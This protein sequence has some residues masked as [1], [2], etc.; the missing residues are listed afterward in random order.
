MNN[1][2][3]GLDILNITGDWQAT[4]DTF[5]SDKYDKMS[6]KTYASWGEMSFDKTFTMI[7]GEK[8]LVPM[9][10]VIDSNSDKPLT[11]RAGISA[12]NGAIPELG[13]RHDYTKD[14][15]R[16]II[17]QSQINGEMTAALSVLRKLDV[18]TNSLV[19]GIHTR[20]NNLLFQELSAGKITVTP[21]NNPDGITMA[22]SMPIPNDNK[23]YAGFNRG[24]AASWTSDTA[25]PIQDLIDAQLY[26]T[27]ADI[28]FYKWMFDKAKWYEFIT[29]PNVA[30]VINKRNG[31]DANNL[32]APVFESDVVEYL[33]LAGIAP[34]EIIDERVEVLENNKSVRI[35]PWTE[36]N[37]SLVPEGELAEVKNATPVN[38]GAG[39]SKM[40]TTENGRI[41]I[42]QTGDDSRKVQ[43]IEVECSA[44]PVLNRTK[45]MIILN[46][47]TTDPW[48]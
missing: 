48:A 27:N 16:K 24:V 46:T 15:F 43:S 37:V 18:T 2:Q 5:L 8:E 20:L 10:A 21:E 7:E 14:D 47:E 36:S 25:T 38:I 32:D 23:L 31:K 39:N 30:A 4:L 26:A 19:M 9:A 11:G 29:H 13:R 12:W 41:Q 1:T 40:A 6:W 45:D 35:N 33:L 17:L 42:I 3:S 34:I 44:L 22:M 28:P